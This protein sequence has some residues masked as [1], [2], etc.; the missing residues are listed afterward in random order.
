MRLSGSL[1]PAL[2]AIPTALAWTLDSICNTA[3]IE[4]ALPYDA[5]LGLTLD[6][7]SLIVDPIY[8]FTPTDYPTG[9]AYDFCNVTFSYTRDGRNDNIEVNY[10]LPTP[11][12]FQNRYLS[13]GGGGY[14]INSGATGP[15]DGVVYGAVAGRT[16]GGFG[17]FTTMYN[18]NGVDL[19]ANG[20]INYDT[21]FSFGYKAHR[22]LSVLGKAFARNVYSMDNSTKLYA[23]YEG[24][25][26]GGREGWSQIQRY[27]DEWDGA[28]V[29]A[30]AFRFAFQQVNHLFAGVAEQTLGY[31]P[32]PCELAAITNATIKACDPLDGRTDGVV[33]RVDLCMQQ[34][35]VSQ[36]IG[37]PYNCPAT[38]EVTSPYGVTPATPAQIGT[39]SEQATQLIQT[40][41]DGLHDSQGQQA[42]FFYSPSSTYDDA[43]PSVYDNST[44]KWEVPISGLGQP[45]VQR[46]LAELETSGLSLDGVTYDTLVHWMYEGY[47]KFY[48]TLMTNWPDLRAFNST[49]GKV[50]HY[51]GESDFS[52]PVYS[53]VRYWNSVR[54]IM[55]PGLGYND[56]VSA[57]SEWYKLYLIPGAGHCAKAADQPNGPFPVTPL[58]TLIEWVEQGQAPDKLPA[59]VTTAGEFQGEQ[60]LCEY[61]LRPYWNSNGSMICEFSQ[62]SVDS[63]LYDLDAFK[64]PVY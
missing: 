4:G 60:D 29:G 18:V 26:E 52:I 58:K 21:L 49:G 23:Y 55:Y 22:E 17:A 47:Q 36:A 42:Y 12:D 13:T 38:A 16:D 43:I 11:D 2:L 63:F 10:W 5:V 14:A 53:S 64:I 51:H 62:S 57:L 41:Y 25:S 20:S 45:F 35:N 34:Y 8:N 15:Q 3:S 54:T 7:S 24:C 33:S 56:S 9:P 50:I 28:L 46:S 30:P 27:G 31:V 59:N 61:P 6:S 44:G 19:I 37:T 48:D 1:L 40:L 32:S 39:V